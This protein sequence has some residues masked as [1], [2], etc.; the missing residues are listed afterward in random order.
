MRKATLTIHPKRRS[1]AKVSPY[2]Y[3]H[4]VED[5]RDHMEA[6]LDLPLKSM[7]FE[8][9]GEYGVSLGWKPYTNGKS[10]LYELEPAAPKHA[11]HSQKIRLF[12][13]D[14]CY[15]G[16]A[17]RF[18]AR[19]NTVYRLV[20]FARASIELTEMRVQIVS[21]ATEE[22]LSES[23]IS[24]KGHNW[25][26][27]EAAL[28]VVDSCEQ[29]ELRI[30]ISSEG[31]VWRDSV[32]TGLLWL[33]HVSL[34]PSDAAGYVRRDVVDK[35]LE[36]KAGMMRLAGN[37]ISAY[38]WEHGVGPVYERPIM[39][40]EA[41]GGWAN[42]YFGTDEFIQFCRD[43]DNEPLICVN[44]GSGTPEEAV[45]WIQ[46]C[47]GDASTPMGALRIKNGFPEPYRVQYW[48]IGNEIYGEWQV[49]HCDAETFAERCNRFAQ[50]MR[51][52]DPSIKLLVCGHFLPEWNRVLAEKI[53]E[54]FDYLT[55]HI[56]HGHGH[57]PI[58]A[59]TPSEVRY[60]IMTA[61]PELTRRIF[62]DIRDI[63][64]NH[65][66]HGKV[67][68]AVTEYNTMYYNNQLRS[69]LPN[70]HTLEAAVANAGNFNEFIRWADFAEIGSYSDLVNGWLGGLIRVGDFYADQHRGK[71]AGW[72]GNSQL[73]YGTPTFH[74]MKMYAN[75]SFAH[76]V[77]HILD[78]DTYQLPLPSTLLDIDGSNLPVLDVVCGVDDTGDRLTVFVV[79]R[80][81]VPIKLE[82]SFAEGRVEQDMHIWEVAGEHYEA[83]NDVLCPDRIRLEHR[84]YR[85][86]DGDGGIVL[87]PHSASRL[88]IR[89]H[90]N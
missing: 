16:I 85:M 44:A 43:T 45:A 39:V 11:G 26:E 1:D 75:S 57:F 36:L 53:T 51:E 47:N 40:N 87:Q 13:A 27:Y 31:A 82:L 10:T 22:K 6:M 18:S 23:V 28:P 76:V 71:L 21:L 35:T 41:W 29:A 84:S 50:A 19:G 46:Y 32:A 54:P 70:E 64:Q 8:N 5:I 42:K 7:D 24:L 72:S 69:G 38:H 61:F 17:Q 73:V 52:A 37:Y 9:E 89:L 60:R 67:K 15:A 86:A 66:I 77:E 59:E 78:C 3:G 20:V 83:I 33:D 79:N 30:W 65:P 56:Y 25:Q 80:E 14:Q 4:F 63:F 12:A 58:S 55:V 2:V 62:S 88:D 74:V 49:G 90:S 81:L 48:E 68:V 34:L